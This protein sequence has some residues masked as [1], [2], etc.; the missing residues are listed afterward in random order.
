MIEQG[1]VLIFPT[2]T[3]YGLGAD[4]RNIKAV[5]RL[6]QIKRRPGTKPFTLLVPYPESILAYTKETPRLYKLIT[7]FWPG[8]LT[9]VV[10]LKDQDGTI[11]LRMPDHAVPLA[12]M[13]EKGC[14]LAAP[15]A[16]FQGQPPPLTCQEALSDLD[17]QIDVALDAGPVKIGKSS[18]VLDL[19]QAEPKILRD[20]TISLE[21]VQ[22]AIRKKSVLFVCTGNSCRSVMAHYVLQDAVKAKEDVEVDSAGTGVFVKI[23]ASNHT[24]QL[25][26]EDGI[27]ATHHM[28]K[29]VTSLLLKK[30]D[31][32]F[33]MTG[34]H[35][36]QILEKVPEVEKRIYML[37]EFADATGSLD[38]PD[39]V[40]G[41]YQI[42]KECYAI[43]K[44]A[45]HRIV[46][47]L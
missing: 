11:G 27:D 36:A 25:L 5:D 38:I 33:V 9:I 22:K 44:E 40:G 3:V 42:Y 7:A 30:A 28:S 12:L 2:E 10:P 47:L 4:A 35:R 39:P 14:H 26:R 37:K 32:I 43:I 18:T 1:K 45:V 31:L 13:K 19:T 21:Q 24:I 16:N 15:S 8:P 34:A 6:R 46:K 20:G 29:P 17:G 23:P 41:T